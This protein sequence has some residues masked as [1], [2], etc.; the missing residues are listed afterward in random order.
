M[1]S[2]QRLG[3]EE[4]KARPRASRTAVS[5][6]Q[7]LRLGAVGLLL[8]FLA[9]TCP[10]ASGAD[11]I[12]CIWSGVEKILVIGD[13]HGDYDNFEAIIRGTG[14][15]DADL[16]WSAG[17]TH[18]VQT[19]DV[20]DRGPDA[21]KIFD[22]LMRLEGEA[23]AAGGMVHVLI[24]NHEELNI[25]GVIFRYP[26]YVTLNQ[27]ISFL[28]EKYRRD[29]ER[30]IEKRVRLAREKGIRVNP[31]SVAA[32]Y[33]SSL[34]NNSR[35][36]HEYLIGFNDTYGRWLLRHNIVIKIDDTVFVHGGMS[37]KYSLWGLPK[38][39]DRYRMELSDMQRAEVYG[40][41]VRLPQLEIVYRSDGPLWYRDLA[42][43]PEQDMLE[44]LN[45]ILANLGAKHLVI[46]HTPRTAVTIEQ[47]RRFG[48]KVWIVDTGISKA[49]NNNLSALKIIDGQFIVWSK[50][51]EEKDNDG[52]AGAFS[53]V[54]RRGDGRSPGAP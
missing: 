38:L 44:E 5:R 39:N 48:G 51:H 50:G 49:Y 23:R 22:V 25:G 13:L 1:E 28:P 14:L 15:V 11:Q 32:E 2:P 36:Q 54:L 42:T 52:L 35:A 37:E 29:Q 12:P 24:G 9:A 47:M 26:D 6:R 30:E 45:R 10:A 16:R 4:S 8:L 3:Q 18:F 34:K 41:P 40:Y 33:W 53:V 20:M 21:R 31:E 7:A 43:V 19:G 17:N 46:A 27:F